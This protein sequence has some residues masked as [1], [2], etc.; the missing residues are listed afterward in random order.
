MALEQE[1]ERLLARVKE[2]EGEIERLKTESGDYNGGY[3]TNKQI[4]EAG[5]KSE[6]ESLKSQLHQ[7]DTALGKRD[8]L[9]GRFLDLCP[10]MND[11]DPIGPALR[12]ACRDAKNL[13]RPQ[14]N[15]KSHTVYECNDGND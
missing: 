1:N 5:F 12:N 8:E 13:I 15:H 4:V 2:L 7:R 9:L 14:H 6:V 11:D 3:P 10:R